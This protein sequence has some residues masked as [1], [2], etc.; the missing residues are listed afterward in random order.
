MLTLNEYYSAQRTTSK[1]LQSAKSI[2]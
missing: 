2:M 1:R